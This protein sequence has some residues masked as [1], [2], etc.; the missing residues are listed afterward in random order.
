VWSECTKSVAKGV[1]R[2]CYALPLHCPALRYFFYV[3]SPHY[4]TPLYFS[5]CFR[6]STLLYPTSLCLSATPLSCYLPVPLLLYPFP[7]RCQPV[8]HAGFLPQHTPYG[9][10][11]P[12]EGVQ[13][14]CVAREV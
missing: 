9:G 2:V 3:L 6:C 14:R 4:A 13:H 7:L 8:P 5:T 11:T 1:P 12:G 10:A